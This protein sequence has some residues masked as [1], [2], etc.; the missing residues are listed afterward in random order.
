[1]YIHMYTQHMYTLI[2]MLLHA[3]L[4]VEVGEFHLLN[5]TRNGIEE[6]GERERGGEIR[7]FMIHH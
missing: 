6:G 4:S 5:Q 2:V 7:I 3:H 1:M